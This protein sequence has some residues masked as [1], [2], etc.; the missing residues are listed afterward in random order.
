MP[1]SEQDFK[2]TLKLWASG[3]SV[4]TTHNK[5]D[6]AKGLTA[7]SFSSVSLEPMQILICLNKLAEASLAVIANNTFAVNIL[8]T[9]QTD[10]SKRFAGAASQQQRFAATNWHLG[11]NGSPIIADSLASLE[12]TTT[13]QI[14]A[15]SHWVII[16][17]VQT[18]TCQQLSPLLY[19]NHSYRK[20]VDR[21]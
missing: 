9:E 2:A 7:T 5:K 18:T 13:K 6:G 21:K 20:L 3:V 14:S 16:A 19:Y 11:E 10:L 8:S 12:C 1:I 17:E 4:V 15:G